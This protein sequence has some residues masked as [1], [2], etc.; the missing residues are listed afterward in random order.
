MAKKQFKPKV[1]RTQ[2]AEDVQKQDITIRW[3][4]L[5]NARSFL[6]RRIMCGEG[7]V[8]MAISY[9]LE[10]FYS[11]FYATQFY[12]S[13]DVK[14]ETGLMFADMR[15]G[16]IDIEKAFAQCDKY[17]YECYRK[18]MFIEEEMMAEEGF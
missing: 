4:E 5:I 13:Q 2:T 7:S 12:V 18:G 9:F 1:S 11:L 8:T 10:K 17:V 6:E 3:V 16:M 15:N 14:E